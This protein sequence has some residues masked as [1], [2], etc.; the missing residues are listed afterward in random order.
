MWSGVQFLTHLYRKIAIQKREPDENFVPILYFV[1][2]LIIIII[3]NE[4]D[5][6]DKIQLEDKVTGEDLI[7]TQCALT[8]C[9]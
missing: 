8:P 4:K 5:W 9:T 1:I 6:M 3:C 7:S 2:I